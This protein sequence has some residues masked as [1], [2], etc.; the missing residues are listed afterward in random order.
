MK[1]QVS[2]EKS[3]S[4]WRTMEEDTIVPFLELLRKGICI[5]VTEGLTVIS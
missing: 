4:K 3:T 5:R 1:M 2:K